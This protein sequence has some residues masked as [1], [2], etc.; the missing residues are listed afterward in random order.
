MSNLSRDNFDDMFNVDKVMNIQPFEIENLQKYLMK[1]RGYIYIAQEPNNPFLKI[2]R[3][4]KSPWERASTLSSS[5]ILNQFEIKFSCEF[6]NQVVAEKH[7]HNALKKYRVKNNREFFST[8][9]ET[10]SKAISE[11]KNKEANL[12]QLYFYGDIYD[13]DLSILNLTNFSIIDGMKKINLL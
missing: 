1:K 4:S 3:T 8:N 11:Y 2:G 9:I 5:G 6:M 10:A 7:I 12:M 13:Y